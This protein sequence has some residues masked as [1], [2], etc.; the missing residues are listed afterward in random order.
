MELVTKLEI[1]EFSPPPSHGALSR[2]ERRA[3]NGVNN[4]SS[5]H[6]EASIQFQSYEVQRA[7]R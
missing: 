3:I 1:R 6:E 4:Q 7:Y 2:E 5:L